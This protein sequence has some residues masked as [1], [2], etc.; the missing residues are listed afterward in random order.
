MIL[1]S[2]YI[3]LPL[4]TWIILLKKYLSN[5]FHRSVD[6]IEQQAKTESRTKVPSVEA[7]ISPEMILSE[8]EAISPHIRLAQEI[9]KNG[10]ECEAIQEGSL[11]IERK[12]YYSYLFASSP[13]I[14]T[15]RGCI[16]IDSNNKRNID[17]IQL[18]QR[19]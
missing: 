8:Y 5:L 12:S 7:Q 16:T 4:V 3:L 10:I 17:L 18:I 9:I 6:V 15:N 1:H 19:N 2:Y 11:P 14:V 13:R